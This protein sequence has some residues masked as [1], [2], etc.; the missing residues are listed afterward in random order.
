MLVYLKK[1]DK[2]YYF[3]SASDRMSNAFIVASKLRIL[4]GRDRNSALMNRESEEVIVVEN[5]PQQH[6]SYDCGVFVMTMIDYIFKTYL[7]DRDKL[8]DLTQMDPNPAQIHASKNPHT[9]SNPS[10]MNFKNEVN[11]DVVNSKRK[12]IK[13]LIK[14]LI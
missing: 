10:L 6:N 4:I 5:A 7:Q 11:Q 9:I 8:G 13:K 14:Q 2:F 3:D 1:V 12:E